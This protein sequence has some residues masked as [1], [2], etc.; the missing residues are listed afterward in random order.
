MLTLREPQFLI[1]AIFEKIYNEPN[2]HFLDR[3]FVKVLNY[4]VNGS[5]YRC[6]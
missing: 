3:M 1:K 2:K 5:F 6:I 4:V